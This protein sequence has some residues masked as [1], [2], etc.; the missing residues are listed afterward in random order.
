MHAWE[1][2]MKSFKS[3]SVYAMLSKQDHHIAKEQRRTNAPEKAMLVVAGECRGRVRRGVKP[4][5]R[6][7]A[8]FELGRA[9]AKSEAR[10]CHYGELPTNTASALM[11]EVFPRIRVFL[12]ATCPEHGMWT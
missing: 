8:L 4:T 6:T 3:V 2:V 1:G 9:P 10:V 7:A 12:I 11:Q 5:E